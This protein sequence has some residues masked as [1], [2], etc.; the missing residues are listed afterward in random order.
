M[1][2]KYIQAQKN[3]SQNGFSL[4]ESMIASMVSLIF[5]SLGANFVLAAN[6]QKVV[7]K[8]NITMSNFIQSDL[9]GIKYQANLIAKD[10]TNAKCAPTN[11]W[12]GYGGALKDKLLSTASTSNAAS[13]STT[14]VKVLNHDYTMTRTLGA[15]STADP[16]ILP[17]SYTFTR[18]GAT[19]I[20]HQ[21]YIELIPNA[22][23]TCPST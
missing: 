12:Q 16:S 17:I 2:L 21:L 4:L 15:I 7:A 8:R 19:A 14:T 11:V 5:M 10:N 20:E 6:I 23:F 18:A 13:D 1:K 22:A 3:K 9:E